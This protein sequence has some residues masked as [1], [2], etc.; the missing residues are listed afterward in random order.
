[1]WLVLISLWL[2]GGSTEAAFFLSDPTSS[3]YYTFLAVA[4]SEKESDSDS[5]SN[6]DGDSDSRGK[7]LVEKNSLLIGDIHAN[8]DIHLKR[9][10]SVEGD[11]SAVDRIRGKRR[12]IGQA[13]EGALP[14]ALPALLDEATARALADR[15][16]EG[17]R[18]FSADEVVDDVIFVDGE[19]PV[20]EARHPASIRP[21]A[22][23]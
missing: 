18:T 21:R 5:G 6:S 23:L 17:N 8:G 2:A 19:A 11:A 4:G 14:L 20:A 9:G 16:F 13:V 7:I 1:V 10:S 15:V 3:I 22:C 12:V